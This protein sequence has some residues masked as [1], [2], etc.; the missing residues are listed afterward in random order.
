MELEIIYEDDDVVVVNKPAGTIVHR[1]PGRKEESL[2]DYLAAKRPAMRRVGSVERPGVVHRLDIETSGVMVFAKND[3]SYR[4]LRGDFE[5]HE[6]IIK[7]Y[8][9]VLHGAPKP[10]HGRL[11]TLVARKADKKRMCVVEEGGVRAV[12][13]WTVL[14]RQGPLSLVEFVIKTGRMH[15]IRLH[16]AHLGHPIVG[17]KLYGDKVKDA[18]LKAKP[19]RHLLHAVELGFLHP[20]TRKPLL[21][22]AHP[23]YDMIYVNV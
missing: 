4:A 12:S 22:S 2:A 6:S 9:A 1:A 13:E 11:E 17:D 21:F 18:R 5:S 19:Q 14:K 16:S 23:P 8:L 15:Q 10:S 3:F 7:T 20:R